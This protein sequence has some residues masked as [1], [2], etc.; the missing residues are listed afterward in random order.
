MKQGAL[1][2]L[3]SLLL[4]GCNME[5]DVVSPWKTSAI[6]GLVFTIIMIITLSTLTNGGIFGDAG[7]FAVFLFFGILFFTVFFKLVVF[8]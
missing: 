8:I 6:T 4:T 3:S 7:T 5:M 1:M 2:I